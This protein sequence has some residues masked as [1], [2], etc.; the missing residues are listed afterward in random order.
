[1]SALEETRI[2]LRCGLP[3]A[4]EAIGERWSFLILRAAYNGVQHFEDFL[5]TLGIARNIL[6]DRLGRLVDG[7]IMV[8]EPCA[9]DRRKIEYRLTEKGV[10]LLPAI[11][12][13]RQ[14]G[15][16]YG[17]GEPS[18]P[19]LVD[20]R[21]FRPI[22]T[23]TIRAHDDRYIGWSEL[24]WQDEATLSPPLGKGRPTTSQRLTRAVPDLS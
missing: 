5:K 4:L 12:A 6:S 10:D 15:E 19:V 1:M 22:A 20:T 18:N 3:A 23:I 9:N 7:G 24:E 8:R 11:L 16:K 17:S 13:L 2:D 21:D 14:W